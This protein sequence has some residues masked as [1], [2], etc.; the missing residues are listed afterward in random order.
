MNSV[1]YLLYLPVC[2]SDFAFHGRIS[3]DLN[4]LVRHI[5]ALPPLHN[6]YEHVAFLHFMIE[7]LTDGN[8]KENG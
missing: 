3:A 7:E 4:D 8:G 1:G 2:L 5:Y 6:Y